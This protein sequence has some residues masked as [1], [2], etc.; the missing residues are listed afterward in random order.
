MKNWQTLLSEAVEADPR[1]RS[2]VADA[3]GVSRSAISQLLSGSY[4]A[5]PEP[6]GCKV[7][8][9]YGRYR[10]TAGALQ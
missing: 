7:I 5:D 3:I 4:P 9:V 1:G 6:M 8:D 10:L 2:G